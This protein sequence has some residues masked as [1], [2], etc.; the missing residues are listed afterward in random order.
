MYA[1]QT[2]YNNT[3]QLMFE[4]FIYPAISI[5]LEIINLFLLTRLY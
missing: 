1:I 2:L 3:N 4:S 5:Y